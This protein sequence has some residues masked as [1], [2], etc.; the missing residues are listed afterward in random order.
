MFK[1]A[2]DIF[3]VGFWSSEI[4]L[5]FPEHSFSFV[6][7][8]VVREKKSLLVM[9]HGESLLFSK[10]VL[11]LSGRKGVFKVEQ[12]WKK[13]EEMCLRVLMTSQYSSLWNLPTAIE[14]K[15]APISHTRIVEKYERWMFGAPTKIAATRM[16]QAL[17]K[18]YN[19]R[20]VSVVELSPEKKVMFEQLTWKQLEMFLFASHLGYYE[21]PR[22]ITVATMCRV[23]GVPK[24]VVLSHL[25]KAEQKVLKT[26]LD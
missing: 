21:W 20:V 19:V 11:F 15:M 14:E 10:I 22:K 26:V 4:G 23:L 24:T 1:V 8:K 18:K 7:S 6:E 3:H 2:F 12:I 25:R 5:Q 17:K 16:Y 13:G 9:V